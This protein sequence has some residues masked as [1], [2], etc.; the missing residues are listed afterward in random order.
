MEERYFVTSEK[1]LND[2]LNDATITSGDYNSVRLLMSGEIDSF[3]GF[4]WK[5]IGSGRAEG[6]LPVVTTV[7]TSFAFHKSA[8]GHAV[9]IDMDTKV[10]YVAHKASWLSMG[11]WKAGSIIIDNEGVVPVE[12]L[13]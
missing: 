4:M 13:A 12:S 9:G 2:L 10:D 7:A 3:M 1:G 8:I 5:V 6:G 11:L